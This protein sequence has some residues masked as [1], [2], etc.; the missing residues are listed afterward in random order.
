MG[1]L[2]DQV[3]NRTADKALVR[4]GTIES[5]SDGLA[6]VRMGTA[7]VENVTWLSHYLP[8]IGD[9][10]AVL[11]SGSGWLI[12]GAVER[13]QRAYKEPET[14]LVQPTRRG[15]MSN[16]LWSDSWD[17]SLSTPSP[18]P[19]APDPLTEGW[20]N[21][22]SSSVYWLNSGS[23]LYE[24]VNYSY[25]QAG[26]SYLNYVP[27]NGEKA[28]FLWYPNIADLLPVEAVIQSVAFVVRLFRE[29]EGTQLRPPLEPANPS[30][31]TLHAQ[32]ASSAG[33]SATGLP[34]E[35]YFVGEPLRAEGAR[36]GDLVTMPLPD[37]WISGMES[38]SITGLAL[39]EPDHGS[40]RTIL[41]NEPVDNW[42]VDTNKDCLAL[43]VTYMMPFS[44]D[45]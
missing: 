9:R 10:V 16:W 26:G 3:L 20:Q 15:G 43:Q 44:E 18:D 42:F 37:E 33:E 34:P 17:D 45:G 19:K 35:T 39:W 5:T 36:P 12:L 32:N 41:A 24:D 40:Q 29:G 38:G 4:Y 1:T 31:I 14:I 28:M 6:S 25:S 22:F 27:S 30:R 8:A 11:A 7:V 23:S 13:V 21:V 2:V